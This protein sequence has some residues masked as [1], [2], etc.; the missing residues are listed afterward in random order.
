MRLGQGGRNWRVISGN[1][2]AFTQDGIR[3]GTNAAWE[4]VFWNDIPVPEEVAGTSSYDAAAVEKRVAGVDKNWQAAQN[5]V[6]PINTR[7]QYNWMRWNQTL[8]GVPEA[9]SRY[10]GKLFSTVLTSAALT[11]AEPA[12]LPAVFIPEY[13]PNSVI[14][15]IL[16]PRVTEGWVGVAPGFGINLKPGYIPT[17]RVYQ[18]MFGAKAMATPAQMQAFQAYLATN[19]SMSLATETVRLDALRRGLTPFAANM[20]VGWHYLSQPMT[21]V[22]NYLT[23]LSL[24]DNL[25]F[26]DY[27]RSLSQF[28]GRRVPTIWEQSLQLS[29]DS[30]RFERFLAR[31]ENMPGLAF[32]IQAWI[33]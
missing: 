13:A 21:Q 5:I 26:Q 33:H 4:E 3:A 19:R 8:Y 11:F 17:S 14:E 7:R 29:I 30:D 16:D 31:Q 27:Q 32:P 25:L 6:D 2:V 1:E 28:S 24:R 9:I 18:S 23:E 20:Q 10:S 15:M 22:R 12:A